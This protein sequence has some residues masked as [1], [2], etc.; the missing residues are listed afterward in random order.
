[1]QLVLSSC[2]VQEIIN[3][4]INNHGQATLLSLVAQSGHA[5]SVKFLLSKGAS[6][7]PEGAE[8][9]ILGAAR[10]RSLTVVKVSLS[11]NTKNNN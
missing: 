5:A 4:Q 11:A 2:Q 1:M 7:H 10:G 6:I 3:T 8:P 9:A